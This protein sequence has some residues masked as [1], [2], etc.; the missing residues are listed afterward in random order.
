MQER[1]ERLPCVHR[2]QRR[3]TVAGCAGKRY[4]HQSDGPCRWNPFARSLGHSVTRLHGIGACD[5]SASHERNVLTQRQFA[6]ALTGDVEDGIGQCRCR[7]WRTW[8]A[9]AS[10]GSTGL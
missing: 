2:S 8:L 3:F 10:D 1:R 9:D 5:S 7:W 4:R 6:N